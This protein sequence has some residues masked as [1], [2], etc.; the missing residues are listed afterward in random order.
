[1][2]R[3]GGRKST[4]AVVQQKLEYANHA[5]RPFTWNQAGGGSEVVPATFG[6]GVPGLA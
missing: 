1:M 5:A 6:G 2:R 4:H 3:D